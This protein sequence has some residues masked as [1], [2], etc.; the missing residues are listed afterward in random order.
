[1]IIG[2][3]IL[4]KGLEAEVKR[5]GVSRHFLF[6]GMVHYK[7]IPLYI[8]IADI[9][10]AP[11]ISKRNRKTGVSPLKVFE[12]M[13]CGKPVVASRIEGM[14]FVE[15]EGAGRLTEPGD[16]NDL[17]EALF[18]LLTFPKKRVDMGQKGLKI[19]QERFSWD[20]RAS[21]IEKILKELA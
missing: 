2:N 12:Y 11:F 16:L 17:K 10:V 9:G 19:A 18:D 1:M 7:Q 14:E 6:T 21:K 8:N 3:G 4:R 5:L 15:A 13:A 20:S